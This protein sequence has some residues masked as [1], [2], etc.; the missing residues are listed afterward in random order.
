MHTNYGYLLNIKEV[1]YALAVENL[2]SQLNRFE[3]NSNIYI[4]YTVEISPRPWFYNSKYRSLYITFRYVSLTEGIFENETM[5]IKVP[6]E[7]NDQH[8][9]NFQNILVDIMHVL[10]NT[11]YLILT[12]NNGEIIYTNFCNILNENAKKELKGKI[13]I[14]PVKYL[15]K[16]FFDECD[17]IFS[18]DYNDYYKNTAFFV[19]TN[20]DVLEKQKEKLPESFWSCI[21]AIIRFY[22][23]EEDTDFKRGTFRILNDFVKYFPDKLREKLTSDELLLLEVMI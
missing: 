8:H 14:I 20:L 9:F 13:G 10:S 4:L 18:V 15:Q 6:C 7:Y 2:I 5:D 19:K 16:G 23:N 21:I 22:L 1:H 12:Y 17:I 3:E 11:R